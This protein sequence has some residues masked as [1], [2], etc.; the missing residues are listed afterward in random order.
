MY[1]TDNPPTLLPNVEDA[2][3]WRNFRAQSPN[4][5]DVFETLSEPLPNCAP[6]PAGALR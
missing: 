3:T 6:L 1:D 2:T 5:V 4:S